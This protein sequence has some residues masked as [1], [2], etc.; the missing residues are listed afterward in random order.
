MPSSKSR[1]V[2]HASKRRL[3]NQDDSRHR[4]LLSQPQPS[5]SSAARS[6]CGREGAM[7]R[8]TFTGWAVCA[9]LADFPRRSCRR[10]SRPRAS[11]TRIRTQSS[12]RCSPSWLLSAGTARKTTTPRSRPQHVGGGRC[13]ASSLP[14]PTCRPP[15]PDR[16]SRYRL[17]RPG[18]RH[19]KADWL[20]QNHSGAWVLPWMS[21]AG[22]FAVLTGLLAHAL[23]S[24]SGVPAA[25]AWLAGITASAAAARILLALP[26]AIKALKDLRP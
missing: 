9:V 11:R 24:R 12:L 10:P 17:R 19:P 23:A 3:K 26:G 14:V 8:G 13:R 16:P 15:G 25:T 2:H 4:A 7:H 21:A 5:C 18:R 20:A 6:A 1:A 22:L